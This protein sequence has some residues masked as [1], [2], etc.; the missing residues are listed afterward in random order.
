LPSVAVA[1]SVTLLSAGGAVACHLRAAEL[2]HE[3]GWLLERARA[4]AA[5]YAATLDSSVAESQQRVFDDCRQI[6]DRAHRWQ[7][8]EA[9]SILLG[10]IGAFCSYG[11][12]L[13]RRL[14]V[15]RDEI[16]TRSDEP[17]S[18]SASAAGPAPR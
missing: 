4:Q 2:R 12:W 9:L 6:L 17:A 11:L 8:A 3:A 1:V 14:R 5:E 16:S 10:V 18:L 15:D 7:S 13:T